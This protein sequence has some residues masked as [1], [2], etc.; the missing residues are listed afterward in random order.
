MSSLLEIPKR[1]L[2]IDIESLDLGPRP[3][4]TQIAMLGYDLEQDEHVDFRFFEYLPAQP[5]MDLTPTPRTVSFPTIWFWMQQP[6]ESR[7][8]F[9]NNLGDEIHEVTL[10]MR[11]FVTAFNRMT[12][13]GKTPYVVVAKGPQFDIVAIETLLEELNLAVPWDYNKVE[14]LRTLLRHRKI[15]PRDVPEPDGFIKHVAFWDSRYQIDQYLA[16][17]M[18]RVIH[19][20]D[21]KAD[22]L[23]SGKGL[24]DTNPQRR[25]PIAPPPT[26]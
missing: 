19:E 5:Q 14:D 10:I 7:L 12:N 4:I 13:N 3:V 20:L 1:L 18:G 2:M 15:D 26:S 11:Q 23:I 17:Q 25:L 16:C 21:P 9:E 8:R 24:P 6:D 22:S